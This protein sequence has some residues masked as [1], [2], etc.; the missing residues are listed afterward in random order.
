MATSRDRDRIEETQDGLADLQTRVATWFGVRRA[1]DGRRQYWTQLG[2]LERVLRP[3]IARVQGDIDEIRQLPRTGDVHAACRRNDRRVHLLDRYWRYFGEK[4]DQ[5]DDKDV[6]LTL[7]AADEITWSCW[8]TPFTLAGATV[9]PAP[10]PYLEPFYTPRAIPRTKPP[11][12][13]Q[14]A[15]ALL[16]STL[17]TLPVP[18]TG[19]P[20]VVHSRPWWLAALAHENGH[21]LER[22]F[23]GGSIY[24][25]LGPAL[26]AAA[27]ADAEQASW[28]GWHEEIFADACSVLWL[29]P[30]AAVATAEMLQTADALMLAED[31]AYP[32]LVVR[33]HLMGQM[34]ADAGCQFAASVPEFRPDRLAGL[35]LDPSDEPLRTRAKTRL[36]AVNA[37]AGELMHRAMDGDHSLPALCGWVPARYGEGGAAAYWRDQLLCDDNEPLPETEAQTARTVLTGGV[38]AWQAIA[39]HEDDG[40]RVAARHRLAARMTALLPLCRPE[41]RR[42]GAEPSEPEVAAADATLTGV[43]FGEEL[44]AEP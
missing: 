37:V 30:A 36:D 18:L 12:D 9:A 20:P 5:R 6:G 1:R 43:L 41:G 4:W 14:R 39:S 8:A 31:D 3:G 26:E 10:L 44:Q 23:A 16:R 34:L 17:E 33:Q 27:K 28:R 40:W 11:A 7:L 29:G 25:S 15:D 42:G 35:E 21:H 22:D 32:S 38:A 2:A 13:V 19:L 24:T